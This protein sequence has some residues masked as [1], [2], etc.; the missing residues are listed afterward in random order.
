VTDRL[1]RE[2][3][4]KL[5]SDAMAVNALVTTAIALRNR[6]WELGG[7]L[8]DIAYPYI[9][10]AR[11]LDEIA[12]Q[13]EPENEVIIDQ[14]VE[15]IMAYEVFLYEDPEAKERRGNPL[16]PELLADLRREQYQ[17]LKAKISQGY[18]P[19]WKDFVRCCDLIRL[20]ST[21][22]EVARLLVEQA[23]KAGWTYDYYL[24]RLK[25]C[26]E[27]AASPPMTFLPALHDIA[28][29]PYDRRLWSFQGPQEYRHNLLPLHLRY[30][31][32]R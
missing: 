23:P 18:V 14:L 32:S 28:C 21:A 5:N 25:R 19:T 24:D 15:S 10:V 2:L 12:H 29:A 17:R 8:S 3:H 27:Q 13:R 20:I 7:C 31:R 4:A 16:Y 1:Q 11:L 22:L 6:F 30:L 26:A 9:Y